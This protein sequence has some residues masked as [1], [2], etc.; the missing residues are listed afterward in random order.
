MPTLME[1]AG[2]R[3][4]RYSEN[5]I[6]APSVR[7]GL[8][9]RLKPIS[10]NYGAPRGN[11][12]GRHFIE[13]FVGRHRADITG[14]V[15]EG[16]GGPCYAREFGG[17]RVARLDLIS[18]TPGYKGATLLADL[19]TGEGVATE[20]YDC[21]LLTQVYNFIFDVQS[22]AAHSWRA[23]RPGGV[24]LATFEGIAVTPEKERAKWGVYWRFTDMSAMRL[25]GGQFG[26]ENVAVETYGN[27]FAA[28]AMLQGLASEDLTE[29]E[30]SY[31]DRTY[32]TTIVLRA[33]KAA[34]KL[35]R[36]SGPKAGRQ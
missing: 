33:R 24:L 31:R 9:R 6:A 26:P 5:A 30:L 11:P 21:L 25:F 23:L 2:R 15:L 3:L 28:C 22:A 34:G 27:V 32:Q 16:A 20:A 17:H 35:E 8:F 14:R 36:E 12:I 19:A 10:T 7:L 1:K 29:R 18:P 4:R 13:D